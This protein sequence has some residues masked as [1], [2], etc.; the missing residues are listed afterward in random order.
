MDSERCPT[1]GTITS[2]GGYCPKCGLFLDEKIDG[3]KINER[4]KK[5]NEKKNNGRI[6][7]FKEK[8]G[9][10]AMEAECPE[11]GTVI[12]YFDP[13]VCPKCSVIYKKDL[14]EKTGQLVPIHSDTAK[15][16]DNQNKIQ[17]YKRTCRNCGN[18]WH[19]LVSREGILIFQKTSSELGAC[20]SGMQSA[21]TCFMCGG[22]KFAQYQRNAEATDSELDRLRS[23]PE[24]GSKNYSEEL[25]TYEK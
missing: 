14:F 11:C 12:T 16:T 8:N 15:K 1:C 7:K 17:E 13:P 22:G 23:C 5:F 25:M 20:G 19:S 21:S 9:R 6:K 2:L 3:E 10:Y 4:I 24:C 18:I